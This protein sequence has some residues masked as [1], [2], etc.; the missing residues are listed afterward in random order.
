MLTMEDVMEREMVT[1]TPDLSLRDLVGVLTEHE[2]TGAPVVAGGRVLGVVSATDLM[3][4][5]GD[6]PGVPVERQETRATEDLGAE[7]WEEGGAL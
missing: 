1:V 4:F 2:I 5:E 6:V 3:E 7:P